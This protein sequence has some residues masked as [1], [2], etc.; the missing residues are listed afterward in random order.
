MEMI[1]LQAHIVTTQVSAV[2]THQVFDLCKITV[3]DKLDCNL[4]GFLYEWYQT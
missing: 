4:I 1:Y 3:S 2:I